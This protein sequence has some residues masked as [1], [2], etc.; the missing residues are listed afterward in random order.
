MLMVYAA[1]KRHVAKKSS[2]QISIQVQ[3]ALTTDADAQ[4]WLVVC[5]NDKNMN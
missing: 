2:V 1:I 4:C 3:A 5:K